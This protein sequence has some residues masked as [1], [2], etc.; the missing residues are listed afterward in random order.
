M[1]IAFFFRTEYHRFFISN[2]YFAQELGE[3]R[4]LAQR[5]SKPG[6]SR[7]QCDKVTVTPQG[8]IQLTVTTR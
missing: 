4:K 1:I 7:R 2:R 3:V 8:K 6:P 5:D